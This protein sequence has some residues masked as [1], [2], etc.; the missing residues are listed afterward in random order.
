MGLSEHLTGHGQKSQNI[1]SG[2]G[3]GAG[4]GE[5]HG[6]GW[7]GVCVCVGGASY[8]IITILQREYVNNPITTPTQPD[9]VHSMVSWSHRCHSAKLVAFLLGLRHLIHLRFLFPLLHRRLHTLPTLSFF[10]R[11]SSACFA[12]SQTKIV[13]MLTIHSVVSGDLVKNQTN[14]KELLLCENDGC[15]FSQIFLWSARCCWCKFCC[16]SVGAAISFTSVPCILSHS[17]PFSLILL[18]L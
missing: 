11:L 5:G 13:T 14:I 7:G 16:F 17:K 2:V 3:R 8:G 6:V 9:H 18:P 12:V 15:M 4:A 1:G 10:C